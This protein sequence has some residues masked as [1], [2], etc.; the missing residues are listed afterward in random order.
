M[1]EIISAAHAADMRVGLVTSTSAANVDA[2]L[3]ALSP[4]LSRE[5]FEV[6]VDANTAERSKP[7]PAAYL[8][9]LDRLRETPAQCIAIE[10]NPDGVRSATAAGLACVAFPNA[11]TVG[12]DFTEAT[13]LVERLDFVEL[14][15][16]FGNAS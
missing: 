4:H 10:D 2:L 16:L 7:D 6:V 13:R 5:S 9:A 3:S 14:Q 11:N 15:H 1:A 8:Y 12:L